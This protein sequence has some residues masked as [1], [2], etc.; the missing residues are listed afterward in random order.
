MIL[1]TRMGHIGSESSGPL[2]PA[3]LVHAAQEFES[4]LMKELTAPLLKRDCLAEEADQEDGSSDAL[5]EFAANALAQALSR[6]G[7][8]GVAE[9]VL[10]HF[11]IS[12]TTA[13]CNPIAGHVSNC[14]KLSRNK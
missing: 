5:G 2:Q 10:R 14:Y 13:V 6:R 8:L 11:P 12:E 7:G 9:E 1:D 3:R 4:Y